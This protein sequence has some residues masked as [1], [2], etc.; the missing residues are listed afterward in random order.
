MTKSP[1]TENIKTQRS[2]MHARF[3]MLAI[4]GVFVSMSSAIDFLGFDVV[5]SIAVHPTPQEDQ[6]TPKSDEGLRRKRWLSSLS[7][8]DSTNIINKINSLRA[9]VGASN[10]NY[11][12]TLL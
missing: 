11:L 3:C 5:N 12:V 8:T 6:T 2:K 10:M 9:S 1:K 7:S 4:V